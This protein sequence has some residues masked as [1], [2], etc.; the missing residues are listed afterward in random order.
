[1]DIT[2]ESGSEREPDDMGQS[3]VN[4]VLRSDEM[5]VHSSQG[6][7]FVC[8][9]ILLA[10]PYAISLASPTAVIREVGHDFQD[11]T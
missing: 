6:M 5:K 1:M 11:V 9:V 4:V 2:V 3:G 8:V 7:C 10:R